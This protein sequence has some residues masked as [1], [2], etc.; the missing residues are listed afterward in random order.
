MGFEVPVAQQTAAAATAMANVKL[1]GLPVTQCT[2][3][4]CHTR[5][6][7]IVSVFFPKEKCL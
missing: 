5:L 2:G 6:M 1:Q 3:D 7:H 4:A